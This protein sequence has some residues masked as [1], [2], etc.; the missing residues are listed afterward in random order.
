MKTTTK[1]LAA[2]VMSLAVAGAVRAESGTLAQKSLEI[3]RTVDPVFPDSAA[4]VTS[5]GEA[6]IAINVSA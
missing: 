6:S 1:F 2:M 3:I 5:T 4:Q